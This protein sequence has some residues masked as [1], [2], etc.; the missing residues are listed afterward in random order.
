M[1]H[2]F[3]LRSIALPVAFPDL[4]KR[5]SRAEIIARPLIQTLTAVSAFP[6]RRFP[7]KTLEIHE[8][9]VSVQRQERT[10]RRSH[11]TSPQRWHRTQPL[12]AGLKRQHG[13]RIPGKDASR[14]RGCSR[15]GRAPKTR[16]ISESVPKREASLLQTVGKQNRGRTQC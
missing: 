14:A 4:S 6:G 3:G 16:R 2:N 8:Q 15:E 9:K 7:S 5:D 10:A 13:I 11:N 1:G 12:S